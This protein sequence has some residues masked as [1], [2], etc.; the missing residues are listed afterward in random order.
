MG[1]KTSVYLT[2]EVEKRVEESGVSLPELI[3]RGL[4]AGVPEPLELRLPGLI[5]SALD[6]WWVAHAEPLSCAV[7]PHDG[8]D[9]KPVLPEPRPE[10]APPR[11]APVKRRTPAPER[12][13]EPPPDD[14]EAEAPRE[15]PKN[16]EHPNMRIKKGFCPDCQG[17]VSGG[18]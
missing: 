14:D 11:K 1:R 10:A 13:A 15:P 9:E 4:A 3:R 6:E 16:C 18:R 5:R 7:A 17:W 2:D 12:A 8:S